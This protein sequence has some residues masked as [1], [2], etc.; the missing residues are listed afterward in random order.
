MN[1]FGARANSIES[2]GLQRP[3]N[4]SE[5]KKRGSR[6]PIGF[7]RHRSGSNRGASLRRKYSSNKFAPVSQT[8]DDEESTLIPRRHSNNSG[9]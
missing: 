2:D 4:Y 5:T 3:G 7:Q 1:T 6:S 8:F 9:V